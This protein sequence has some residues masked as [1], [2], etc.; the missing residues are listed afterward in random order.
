MVVIFPIDLDL[1]WIEVNFSTR[2]PDFYGKLF[3]SHDYTQDINTFKS[4]QV[5][6]GNAK[7]VESSKFRIDDQMLKYFQKS[8]NSC[9][10]SILA[11]AFASIN[12]K[13]AANSITIRIEESL[14]IKVG[15]FIDFANDILKNNKRNIVE[16]KMHY[17]LI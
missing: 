1:D 10:F 8:L 12:H 7:C 13:N 5:P 3:Q 6:I 11:S 4:F 9:C 16:S 17:N 2:E 15:N 14:K